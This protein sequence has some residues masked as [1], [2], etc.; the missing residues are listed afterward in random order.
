M[1]KNIFGDTMPKEKRLAKFNE[2]TGDREEPESIPMIILSTILW[3]LVFFVWAL[4]LI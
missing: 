2:I 4:I 3:G 1:K